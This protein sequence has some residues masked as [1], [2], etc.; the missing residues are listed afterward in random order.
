MNE[1]GYY[2][3]L[4][5]KVAAQCGKLVEAVQAKHKHIEQIKKRL[6]EEQDTYESLDSRIKRL[7]S[8]A[9]K[10]LAGD[11]KS[12]LRY[13]KDVR[14]LTGEFEVTREVIA[15]LTDRTIPELYNELRDLNSKL[16]GGFH[17]CIS[18]NLKPCKA[19]LAGILQRIKG[20]LESFTVEKTSFRQ[21]CAKIQSEYDVPA[22]TL[23]G[24]DRV[25]LKP[26]TRD[27]KNQIEFFE[28]KM[29]YHWADFD[30]P[31]EATATTEKAEALS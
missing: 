17:S 15:N 29:S 9:S 30:A 11:D 5:P 25:D 20:G 4:A 7:N 19:E 23:D 2:D 16:A 22:H 14:K 21:A 6:K 18:Q 12:F 1:Q 13:K 8:S 27:I 31:A 26:Y 24:D 28:E 3:I 10:S